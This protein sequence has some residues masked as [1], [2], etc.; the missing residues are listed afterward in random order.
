MLVMD[1]HRG[2][3]TDA[4]IA[5]IRRP[6]LEARD[7]YPIPASLR[8]FTRQRVSLSLCRQGSSALVRLTHG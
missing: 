8:P 5:D 2:K 4:A 3:A 1:S 7:A 6:A